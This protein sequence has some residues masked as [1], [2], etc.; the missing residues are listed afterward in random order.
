MCFLIGNKLDK[1]RY[2][3]CFKT[4]RVVNEDEIKKFMDKHKIK[5]DHYFETTCEN[6]K[7]VLEV[8]YVILILF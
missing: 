6:R 5:N 7:Q 2:K 4:D 1:E 8:I 3:N